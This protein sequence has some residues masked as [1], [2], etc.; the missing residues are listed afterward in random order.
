M[1]ISILQMSFKQDD[2][3][4]AIHWLEFPVQHSNQAWLDFFLTFF[5][6]R[7]P[8]FKGMYLSIQLK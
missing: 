3:L 8:V 4:K 5:L 6:T 7:L 2:L 1:L